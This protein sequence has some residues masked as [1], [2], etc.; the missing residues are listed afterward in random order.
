VPS[1]P[2]ATVSTASPPSRSSISFSITSRAQR[3]HSLPGVNDTLRTAAPRWRE[4]RR[5][6]PPLRRCRDR[7]TKVDLLCSQQPAWLA[8]GGRRGVGHH[9]CPQSTVLRLRATTRHRVL[10][11]PQADP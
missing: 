2:K 11:R 7:K 10:T 1:S 3:P 5:P 8:P 9:R 4:T 6:R